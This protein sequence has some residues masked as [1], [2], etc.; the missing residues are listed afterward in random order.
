MDP[1][2]RRQ[3]IIDLLNGNEGKLSLKELSKH[4]NV[5]QSAL[6]KDLEVMQRQRLIKKV[7]GGLELMDIETKKHD[8]YNSL[9][10]NSKQKVIIGKEAAKLIKDNETIFVDGSS[11]T[12]YFCEELKKT[13]LRN[14]TIITNSIFI[15]QEFL[16]EDNFNV[17]CT[18]GMLNKDIGTF[19]GDLWETIVTN[20]LNSSKFFFSSYGI[21]LENGALD[22]FIPADSSMK[23]AFAAKSSKNICLADSSKFNINGTISWIGFDYIDT[24]I[25][26]T[27]IEESTLKKLK[28]KNIQVIVAGKSN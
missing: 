16:L 21:S 26:D 11:T 7:Y 10:V 28:E 27:L 2:Q 19:G 22:P 5:S 15:P 9:Q 6:Y 23:K 25:T 20:N 12:F 8:F 1:K 14:I 18:G 17:I 4:F 13:D 24:F 3:K